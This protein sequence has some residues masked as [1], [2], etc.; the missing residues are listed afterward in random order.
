MYKHY[1]YIDLFFGIILLCC[2]LGALLVTRS[3]FIIIIFKA[4]PTPPLVTEDIDPKVVNDTETEIESTIGTV[5][6]VDNSSI[7]GTYY[8]YYLYIIVI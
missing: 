2:V 7:T 6:H 5:E 3:I 8:L 4:P 1:T